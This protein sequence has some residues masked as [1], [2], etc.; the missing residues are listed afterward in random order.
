M[1]YGLLFLRVVVG[2]TL[3]GH[4]AQKLFGW[5]EGPGL[6]GTGGWLGSM[7]FRFPRL[8]AVQVAVAETSGLLFA[9]GFLT[10][11]VAVL[12]AAGM[13]VAIMSVHWANGFWVGKNGYEFNL[14]LAAVPIALAAT[15]P[16]RFSVDRALGWDDNLSGLWWGVGALAVAAAGAAFVLM[17]LRTAPPPQPS[18]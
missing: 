9:V 18:A 15:G 3:F 14:V 4:G 17:A 7:G 5:W 2:L 1:S 16:G 8:L 10:P 6:A 12:M 11:F 13:F